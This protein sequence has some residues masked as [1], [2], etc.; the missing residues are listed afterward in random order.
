MTDQAAPLVSA[1]VA[2]K[3]SRNVNAVVVGTNLVITVDLTQD[4]GPS[5]SGKTNLI[6]TTAGS[7]K[8]EGYE[9]VSFG[10]NVFKKVKKA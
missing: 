5:S 9:G 6:A 1:P 7:E 3:G 8:V 2:K 4:L 10:L